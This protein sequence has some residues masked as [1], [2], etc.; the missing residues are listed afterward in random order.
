MWY[1]LHFESDE[2]Q[3]KMSNH[4]NTLSMEDITSKKLIVNLLIISTLILLVSTSISK[5]AQMESST[6]E[7]HLMIHV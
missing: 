1:A 5:N 7:I 4:F 3:I 6:Y 2:L